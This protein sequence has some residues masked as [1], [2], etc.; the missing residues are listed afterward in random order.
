[1]RELATSQEREDY[2][3]WKFGYVDKVL[4]VIA[5]SRTAHHAIHGCDMPTRLQEK[6]RN[7]SDEDRNAMREL[8][9][10]LALGDHLDGAGPQRVGALWG[11]QHLGAAGFERFLPP[12]AT[13]LSLRVLGGRPPSAEDLTTRSIASQLDLVDPVLLV[14]GSNDGIVLL[15]DPAASAHFERKRLRKDARPRTDGGA[16]PNLVLSAARPGSTARIDGTTIAL[17]S[18]PQ[19][20]SLP[21]GTHDFMIAR[22]QRSLLA[23]FV[24]PDGGWIEVR[25]EEIAPEV[26]ITV[27]TA[28]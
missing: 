11:S 16:E 15:S 12:D 13:I 14:S 1:L 3:A 22:G 25:F 27:H 2:A 10:A 17:A 21:V 7:W 18:S 9:C 24:V 8:H 19:W 26:T 5:D 28:D 23:S 4:D 6:L 20:M